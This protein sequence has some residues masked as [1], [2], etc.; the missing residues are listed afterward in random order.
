MKNNSQLPKK[1]SHY[2]DK[3]VHKLVQTISDGI[4][5]TDDQM[6][7]SF[8]NNSFERITGYSLEEVLGKNPKILSSGKQNAEFYQNMWK[9]IHAQGYWQGEIWN[10]KKSGEIYPEILTI[11]SIK[12]EQ[13]NV[14]NFYGV[15]SDISSKKTVEK[16]L[17]ELSML[18]R[19]T[20]TSNRYAFTESLDALIKQ[21]TATHDSLH[22]MIFIDINRFK[23]INETVGDTIG[24]LVLIEISN[25]IK[26]LVVDH[27]LFA[28]YGGD[29]FLLTLTNIVHQ[30][31]A[32]AY[33]EE[34]IEELSRPFYIEGNE[35]YITTSIGISIF[36]QDG[37]DAEKIIHKAEDAMIFARNNGQNQYAFYFE[38][39]DTDS[40]RLLLLESALRKAI[41]NKEFQMFYQPKVSLEQQEI[42]GVEALVRWTSDQLGNVSPG[43]FI[44]LAED[45]GLIIPLSEV[46][47]EK[48]CR[49][50]IEWQTKGVNNL[51][52]SVNIASLHFQ[53]AD[54]IERINTIVTEY[55]CSPSQLE[56][57]L[58]ERT[59]MEDTEAIINKLIR[60]K[61]MG[62]KL[63]IDDFGVGYSSLSYLNR[64]PLN[65]IK[66]DQSFVQKI[67]SL[68]EQQAIV[69]CIILMAHRLQIKVVAE[70]VETK[71]QMKM[72]KQMNCDI[73]QG[74][75]YSK[76]IPG[77]ELLDFLELWEILKQERDVL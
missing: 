46:I 74:Y 57:E 72:L 25:R 33:A 40:N 14:T 66:I 6:R 28:R 48:V 50:I 71:D 63:S 20:Q 16:E 31:E 4:M 17:A 2:S 58:T 21:Q 12:N 44:P 55:N 34:I 3:L 1:S 23:Q 26:S 15:F 11:A 61:N 77:S 30:K 54:F 60:L 70:G 51:S 64:F 65:Y 19:L 62:F 59:L 68:Q 13:G 49:D 76:P 22:A 37:I 73:I 41:Q 10:K 18:D 45:T 5:I 36:P 35:I 75:Y 8:V 43:E 69:D 39:L 24:D 52:V 53:Q 56:I 47:L 38:G 32:A 27:N 29:E 7:I 9:D 67:T 42:I